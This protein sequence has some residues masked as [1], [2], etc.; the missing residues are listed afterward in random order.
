MNSFIA[1]LMLPILAYLL[2]AVPFSLLIVR[3]VAGVDMSADRAGF[4]LCH[5][6]EVACE[7]IKASDEST[8]A[9]THRDRIRE[10]T[11]FAVDKRYCAL[12]QRLGINIDA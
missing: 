3:W 10:L 9:V 12:R 5:D 1:T 8:A 2:G 11:L 4:L 6:L 7:M